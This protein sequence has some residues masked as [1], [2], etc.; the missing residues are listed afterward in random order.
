MNAPADVST[1]NTATIPLPL[2]AQALG[3]LFHRLAP[4]LARL[5]GPGERRLTGT[6]R[7]RV[8]KR[9]L[10][11][12]L[13]KLARMPQANEGARCHVLL[14]TRDGIER[15]ERQIGDQRMVSHQILGGEREI[16]ERVGPL[17]IRLRTAVRKGGLWQR[18]FGTT[19]LGLPLPAIFGMQIVAR[20]RPID[21][22]TLYC[23]VRLRSPLL[24]CL[25]QYSGTLRLDDY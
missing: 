19:A 9:P 14:T 2:Y 22:R 13:L 7:V 18:S 21:A 11:R 8:G 1:G 12:L 25:L 6:L 17:A 16:I 4:V 15:W 23:D 5:H 10:V 24:G 3:P 20:E